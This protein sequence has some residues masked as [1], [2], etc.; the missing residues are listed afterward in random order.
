MKDIDGTTGI[1]LCFGYA[2]MVKKNRKQNYSFL[3]S[4]AESRVDQISIEAAQPNLDLSVLD[5]LQGKT[6]LV[7]ML[8]LSKEEIEPPNL[9]AD[10]IRSALNFLSPERLIVSPDC[11]LKYLTR[12]VAVGKLSSLAQAAA[13]VNAEL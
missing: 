4:L 5:S 6:I 7:G 11:G 10:R 13:M 9:I 3:G 8:D 2:A 12:R 1:H